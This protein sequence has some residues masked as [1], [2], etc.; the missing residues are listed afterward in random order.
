MGGLVPSLNAAPDLDLYAVC[1][2]S[3]INE[4]S[5]IKFANS[6]ITDSLELDTDGAELHKKKK[7]AK[8]AWP[9]RKSTNTL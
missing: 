5:K 6:I 9:G 2:E 4:S 3:S 1:K 8:E 7:Y